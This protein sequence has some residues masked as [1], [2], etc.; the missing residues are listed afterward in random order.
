MRVGVTCFQLRRSGLVA[1]VG[2]EW[3]DGGDARV[4]ARQRR[5][6]GKDAAAMACATATAL[7]HQ[8]DRGSTTGSARLW[9][10]N[11]S[12]CVRSYSSRRRR[13][14]DAV[15]YFGSARTKT[16]STIVGWNVAG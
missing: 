10:P 9:T 15:S 3:L 12:T 14:V 8:R 4:T 16:A 6:G 13:H 7:W 11:D 5:L 2:N 1:R